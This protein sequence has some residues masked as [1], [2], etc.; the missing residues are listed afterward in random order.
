MAVAGERRQTFVCQPICTRERAS[1]S[2]ERRE[3][4]WNFAPKSWGHRRLIGAIWA[5]R[6]FGA[7]RSGRDWL[8]RA[9]SE[10]AYKFNDV[11]LGRVAAD[12]RRP[13]LSRFAPVRPKTNGRR[14][15]VG[16]GGGGARAHYM[17]FRNQ[18]E[19]AAGPEQRQKQR[20]P[21]NLAEAA[22][23]RRS[24]Q[25]ISIHASGRASRPAS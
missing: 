4:G 18:T 25:L 14:R 23:W 7:R 9:H 3:L 1:E 20:R 19:L 2:G 10:V 11:A 16:G 24:P 6:H 5:R 22:K 21:S 17:P 13:T 12:Q 15:R 8:G